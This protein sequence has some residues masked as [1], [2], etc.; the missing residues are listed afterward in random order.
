MSQIGNALAFS[1]SIHH[2]RYLG[3]STNNNYSE[4]VQS[5]SPRT[6]LE[7]KLHVDLSV[8]WKILFCGIVVDFVGTNY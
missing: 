6:G 8:Y 1:K 5:A 3:L 7:V 2:S 4:S